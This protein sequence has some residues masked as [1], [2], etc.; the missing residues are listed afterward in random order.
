LTDSSKYEGDELVSRIEFSQKMFSLIEG[1]LNNFLEYVPLSLE[2]LDVY[3]LKLVTI[4]L[5]I[6]PEIISCFDLATYPYTKSL[7]EVF[8][9]GDIARAREKLLQKEK[10]IRTRRQS[11]TFKDYYD[12]LSNFGYCNLKTATTLLKELNAYMCP[13]E[14]LNAEWWESYNLLKHDKYSNL[15][16]ATLRNA[17][18]SLGAL[19]WLVDYNS[20]KIFQEFHSDIFEKIDFEKMRTL[21]I[22]RS[23]TRI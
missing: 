1:Q 2:H 13:F 8:G 5:E 17:L 4:L 23:H 9:D 18:K 3:S 22:D 21:K 15:K 12:F 7:R 20:K 11:L 16:K 10:K 14:E 6:G 19:F